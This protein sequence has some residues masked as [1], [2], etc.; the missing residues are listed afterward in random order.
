MTREL[1]ED[2]TR[3]KT[4]ES[5][6][7]G[8]GENLATIARANWNCLIEAFGTGVAGAGGEVGAELFTQ[9]G[10]SQEQRLQQDCGCAC[11]SAI[12]DSPHCVTASNK[13]NR[14]AKVA[15]NQLTL[16]FRLGLGLRLI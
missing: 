6:E 2:E 16:L 11:L 5:A 3:K 8:A 10:L 12:A 7:T 4:G 1:R 15:F 13:L 14:M 9:Q